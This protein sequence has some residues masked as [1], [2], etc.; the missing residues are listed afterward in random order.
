MRFFVDESFPKSVGTSLA[1]AGHE[2]IDVRELGRAGVDDHTVFLLA[3]EHKATL[4]TT[5]R[6]FYHT[7]P[8]LY[9]HHCGIIVVSLRQPNRQNI[10]ERLI[11]F[12]EQFPDE[13]LENQVVQLR[14][15]TY[16]IAPK[17]R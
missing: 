9:S 4:L 15:K 5:D 7:V 13:D 14:D 10:Q 6:D 11:W 16:V 12:L 8:H 1:S 3:Q 17:S 2:V